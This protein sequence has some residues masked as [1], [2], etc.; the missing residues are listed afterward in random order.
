[1]FISLLRSDEIFFK[2]IFFDNIC[3]LKGMLEVLGVTLRLDGNETAIMFQATDL[4]PKTKKK[5]NSSRI[6]MLG[7]IERSI[8]MSILP[9]VDNSFCNFR[10][11]K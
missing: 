6:L 7:F 4:A 11:E 8:S 2:S 3:F 1:M 5:L 9:V 10:L